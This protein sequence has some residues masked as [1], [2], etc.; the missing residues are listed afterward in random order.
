MPYY[1]VDFNTGLGHR[2]S[3]DLFEEVCTCCSGISVFNFQNF[4]V[5]FLKEI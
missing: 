2:V 5:I 1:L 4:C 3:E